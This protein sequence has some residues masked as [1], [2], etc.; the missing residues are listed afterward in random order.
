MR[1]LLPLALLLAAPLAAQSAPPR[2]VVVRGEAIGRAPRA[3]LAAVLARPADYAGKPVQVMGTIV[4]SCTNKGCWMQLAPVGAS[5]GLRVTFKDYAFFIPLDAKG[6]SATAEGTLE[7]KRH[8]AK[9]A[10]H[11]R[12]EGAMVQPG[13]DGTATELTFVAYGV[14]LTP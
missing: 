2:P 9:D 1:L 14:E 13:P 8:P 11:L 12:E 4:R 6:M 10:K 5:E 3:D 7:V